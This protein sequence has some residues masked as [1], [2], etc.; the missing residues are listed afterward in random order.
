M[1]AI[2]IKT[3]LFDCD[4]TLFD[5]LSIGMQSFQ[6]AF[7]SI[8]R[9]LPNIEDIKKYFGISADKIFNNLLTEKAEA[10]HA[11]RKYLE[12]QK[13]LSINTK[14]HDGIEDL[15]LHL[16]K[17]S[18]K[19]GI[20]TGRHLDD[21]MFL[22]EAH[23]QK[24][25]FE[26]LIADSMLSKSKPDA[27]GL[28]RALDQLQLN[29]DQALYIGDSVNDIKAAK[30]ISM[31]SVAALWDAHCVES[32]MLKERADFLMHSPLELIQLL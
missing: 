11:F 16:Q 2:K 17:R 9:P 7:D 4:G 29:P 18:I 32:E 22:V 21:L 25:Q 24:F 14:L 1:V 30:S 20:V 6:Y 23:L 27:E 3:V 12:H 5:S 28:L 10:E 31:I 15:L 8:N 19:M 26:V 13:K